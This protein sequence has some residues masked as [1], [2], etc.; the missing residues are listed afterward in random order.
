[1]NIQEQL[2]WKKQKLYGANMQYMCYPNDRNLKNLDR[3][4]EEIKALELRLSEDK[5]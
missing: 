5:K 2:E 4:K 1:M 3:L